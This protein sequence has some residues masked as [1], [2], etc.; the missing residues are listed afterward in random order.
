MNKMAVFRIYKIYLQ[1]EKIQISLFLLD[2]QYVYFLGIAYNNHYFTINNCLYTQKRY[3][4]QLN[5]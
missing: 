5:I 4:V 2:T 1:K 3:I